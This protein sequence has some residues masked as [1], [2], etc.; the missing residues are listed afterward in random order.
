MDTWKLAAQIAQRIHIGHVRLNTRIPYFQHCGNVATDMKKW[1]RIPEQVTAAYLHDVL[2]Y[3]TMDRDDLYDLI[4]DPVAIDLIEWMTLPF[5][6]PENDDEH[7]ENLK[8]FSEAPSTAQHILCCDIKDNVLFTSKHNK[9]LL[10]VVVQRGK[11]MLRQMT[12]KE[13]NPHHRA[14]RMIWRK[15]TTKPGY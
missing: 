4:P 14:R 8:F 10:P 9:E 5:P 12:I 13:S 3:T 7:Q 11:D 6:S 2:N 1:F 15:T